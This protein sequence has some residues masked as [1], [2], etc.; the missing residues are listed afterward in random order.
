MKKL[1]LLFLFISF[2]FINLYAENG[3]LVDDRQKELAIFYYEVGQRYINVGKVK[4]GRS[5]Q[6]KALEI[7]PKLKEEVN[8]KTAI[9]E[10][11]SKIKLEG[12]PSYLAFDDIKLDDIPGITHDKIEINEVTNAP[13]IEYIANLER[14]KHKE[15]AVKFQFN[16]FVRALILQNVDLFNSIVSDEIKVLGKV[17]SKTDFISSLNV[18]SAYLFEDDLNY[19]AFDDFYDLKSLS[20]VKD[21]DNSYAVKVKAKRNN[22]TNKIPFWTDVQTLS[23]IKQYD[24]W[25]LSSIK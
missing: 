4:K 12:E 22:I 20:I 13:K 7:Y 19:L 14:E 25:L 2:A 9:K 1:V 3:F 18:N 24:K 11:D 6:K 17:K 8:M 16:K 5:F 23:F 15:Q 10:I 21:T